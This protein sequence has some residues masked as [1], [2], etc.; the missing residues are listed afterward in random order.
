MANGYAPRPPKIARLGLSNIRMTSEKT[1]V[2]LLQNLSA[3]GERRIE[4]KGEHPACYHSLLW[5]VGAS[6]APAQSGWLVAVVAVDGK[7][8]VGADGVVADHPAGRRA[9]QDVGREVALGQ[10]AGEGGRAGAG[11][12]ESLLP[13]LGILGGDDRGGGPSEDRRGLR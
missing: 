2:L 8:V 11:V 5:R 3:L 13:G 12:D 4:P 10:D 9:E 6:G 7:A 1:I